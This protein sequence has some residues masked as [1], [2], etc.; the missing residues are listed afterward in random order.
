MAGKRRFSEA[1]FEQLLG[2]LLRAGV[3]LSAVL[4]A[5]GGVLYLL[6]HGGEAPSYHVFRGE[7]AEFRVLSAIVENAVTLQRRRSLIQLGLLVLIATPI[8]R[9]AFSAYG[10]WRQGDR[11]YVIITLLVLGLLLYSLFQT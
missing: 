9:V 10:F 2:N 3:S 11:T 4:V 1:Q 6:R 5:I 8:V 7:P